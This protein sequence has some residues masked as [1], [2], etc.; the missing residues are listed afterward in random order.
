[1]FDKTFSVKGTYVDFMSKDSVVNQ[2]K[3]K[4]TQKLFHE[5]EHILRNAQIHGRNFNYELIKT[6]EMNMAFMYIT[7]KGIWVSIHP[8]A[9]ENPSSLSFAHV[10][11]KGV[12]VFFVEN[13]YKKKV[14]VIFAEEKDHHI[15]TALASTTKMWTDC[16]DFNNYNAV[17]D[18]YYSNFDDS[19]KTLVELL[20]F[21][22]HK[23]W[24]MFHADEI[25]KI[26]L[27][28]ASI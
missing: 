26:V 6:E 20:K 4:T 16:I 5:L 18:F 1:M 9:G 21:I 12:R 24:N 3:E 25:F 22:E 15:Y 17:S 13:P 27:E 19:G 10:Q 28:E 14:Y 7:R 8:G 2:T 23:P 11:M